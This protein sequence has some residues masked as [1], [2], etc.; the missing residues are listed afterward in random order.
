MFAKI[1][2][3][4]ILL[5]LLAAQLLAGFGKIFLTPAFDGPDEPA[6]Y[7]RIEVAA[8]APPEARGWF[9]SRDTVEYMKQAPMPPEWVATQAFN[10]AYNQALEK[11]AALHLDLKTA[12][13]QGLDYAAF[14][15]D[16]KLAGDY[17]ARFRDASAPVRYEA[18]DAENWEYQHPPLYYVAMGQLLRLFAGMPLVSRQLLLRGASF[19]MGFAGFAFGLLATR[20]Y[21][22]RRGVANADVIIAAGALYPFLMPAYFIDLARLGNDGMCLLLFGAIWALALRFLRDRRNP[23][24]A[25]FIGFLM[26]LAALT[27][28]FMIATDA[29]LLLFVAVHK[30]AVRDILHRRLLPV[31]VMAG[32]AALIGAQPYLLPGSRG[33]LE[34]AAWLQGRGLFTGDFPWTQ[35]LLNLKYTLVSAVWPAGDVTISWLQALAGAGVLIACGIAFFLWLRTLPRDPRDEAWLP[36]YALAPL[37]GG[38][39]IHSVLAA[40]AYRAAGVTPGYYI[41]ALAPALALMAGTGFARLPAGVRAAMLI[42]TTSTAAIFGVL[43]LLLFAGC[44]TTPDFVHLV[45]GDLCTGELLYTRLA[46]LAWPTAGAICLLLAL[47]ALAGGLFLAKKTDAEASFGSSKRPAK[48]SRSTRRYGNG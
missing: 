1:R 42:F 12:T 16:K 36:L 44:A 33:S 25:G 7:S 48:K 5:L 15:A 20:K 2:A 45:L 14:F 47:F 26:G 23:W 10:A 22:A 29:G 27:K 28:A 37:C 38:L 30:D 19:L 39:L 18:S 32:V 43:R 3:S 34:I 11:H 31:A 17:A 9:L 40:A 46:L 24:L 41:H 8:F 4:H 6:H 35:V 21:L 13:A